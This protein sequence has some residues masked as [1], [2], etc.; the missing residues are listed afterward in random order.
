[1][2]RQPEEE[3]MDDPLQARAYAE[4]DFEAPHSMFMELFRERFG[5]GVAGRVLDLGCGPGD[6]TRRFARA[7]PEVMI[8][9]L[10]GAPVMLQL[11]GEMVE[12]QGL[13]GRIRLRQRRLPD[14]RGLAP[15]YDVIISNS[16]LHHLH[17]PRVMW[18]SIRPHLRPGTIVFVMDLV[19][20]GSMAEACALV[21]EHAAGE[22]PR[23]QGDFYNSLLSAFRPEEVEAQLVAAGLAFL[24]VERVSSRHLL[25]AGRAP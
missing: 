9:A 1:M 20:P 24:T 6:I 14:I 19:R 21:A 12:R 15:G 2:E 8:D 17:D 11:A 4:A 5:A 13:G 3:L 7:Y 18:G 10:D 23:L 25:V 16:L 22:P